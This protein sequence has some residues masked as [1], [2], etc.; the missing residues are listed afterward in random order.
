MRE[1]RTGV[2]WTFGIRLA[3]QGYKLQH[4]LW[5]STTDTHNGT[6]ERF[7]SSGEILAGPTHKHVT[8]GMII[9]Y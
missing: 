7:Y 2:V 4:T 3:M 1:E 8:D 5:F 9:V 6:L